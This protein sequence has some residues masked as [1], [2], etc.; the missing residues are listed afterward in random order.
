LFRNHPGGGWEQTDH[1]HDGEDAGGGCH[2]APPAWEGAF[3]TIR[4]HHVLGNGGSNGFL[5]GSKAGEQHMR[6]QHVHDAGIPARM[7]GNVLYGPWCEDGAL[8]SPDLLQT[9]TDVGQ[10]LTV[11][12]R[13]QRHAGDHPLFE[14]PQWRGREMA[15]EGREPHQKNLEQWRACQ[16]SDIA[17]A[18][19][20]L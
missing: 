17:Q 20:A 3:E 12:E 4:R 14:W 11:G 18:Y 9:M 2:T 10:A 15:P 19:E 16:G 1:T 6:T 5:L 8:S 7:P 13:R